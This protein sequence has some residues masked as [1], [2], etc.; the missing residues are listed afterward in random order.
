MEAGTILNTDKVLHD[1]LD[2][3]GISTDS[4]LYTEYLLAVAEAQT[5]IQRQ[6]KII[7][8]LKELI[9]KNY[10]RNNQ[11]ST[12]ALFLEIAETLG[13]EKGNVLLEIIVNNLR[14][15]YT[16][17]VI[18]VE[19]NRNTADEALSILVDFEKQYVMYHSPTSDLLETDSTEYKT[20]YDL[21]LLAINTPVNI[22]D[23]EDY[24]LLKMI[25]QT[26]K[27]IPQ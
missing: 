17:K 10:D 8:E 27:L 19:N 25:L 3:L 9:V 5:M 13:E 4:A 1:G 7:E 22:I 21:L 11:Q 16:S 6:R 20:I 12:L 24:K 23:N 26:K 2:E 15:I 14:K 18:A